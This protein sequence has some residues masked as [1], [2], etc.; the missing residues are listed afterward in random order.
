[1]DQ[2]HVEIYVSQRVRN[3]RKFIA[4]V[5]PQTPTAPIPKPA[6]A[7]PGGGFACILPFFVLQ[8]PSVAL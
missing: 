5:L 8:R 1:M 2:P 7:Y 3:E 6:A 4:A